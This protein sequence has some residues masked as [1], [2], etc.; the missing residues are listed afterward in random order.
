MKK[1]IAPEM[2]ITK[3]KAQDIMTTSNPIPGNPIEVNA[4]PDA[5]LNDVSSY[6]FIQ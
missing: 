1:F 2:E 5:E 4:T 3:F 6:Q